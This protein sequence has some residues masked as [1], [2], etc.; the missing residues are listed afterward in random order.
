MVK[1]GTVFWNVTLFRHVS[2]FA[3]RQLFDG[4]LLKLFF[5]S[6]DE[7]SKLLRNVS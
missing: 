4:S 7:G 3:F 6:E 5:D 2:L 1:T